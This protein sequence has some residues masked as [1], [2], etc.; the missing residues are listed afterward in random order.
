MTP[1]RGEEYGVKTLQ[2]T[3]SLTDDAS[4]LDKMEFKYVE[5]AQYED[6][7]EDIEQ[8]ITI[9]TVR[10]GEEVTGVKVDFELTGVYTDYWD[11]NDSSYTEI[12]AHLLVKGSMIVDTDD[13]TVFD[14]DMSI[15]TVYACEVTTV[16]DSY[17]DDVLDFNIKPIPLTDSR[18]PFDYEVEVYANKTSIADKYVIN[19][20]MTAEGESLPINGEYY[21]TSAPA[22]PEIPSEIIDYVNMNTQK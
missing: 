19:G 22:F 4:A 1:E 3:V 14:I 2:L 18:L 5:P 20:S 11:E 13:S 21:T 10:N 6:I 17:H 9:S 16:F 15:E 7:K 8:L 12:Y